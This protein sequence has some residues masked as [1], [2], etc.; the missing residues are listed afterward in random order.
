MTSPRLIVAASLVTFAACTGSVQTS[1]TTGPSQPT[2]Y[3]VAPRPDPRPSGPTWDSTGWTL[4]GTQQVNGSTDRDT[5]RV[6][7]AARWDKL[8]LVVSDSDL[9]L[10][11]F[12]VIFATG[13]R[14]SPKLKH[15]FHEGERTAS[16]DLPGDDRHI[17]SL[18][19]LYKNT[20]GGG[21]AR[22]EVYGKDL[23]N[24]RPPVE[25][26]PPP[27][28]P[29]VEFDPTG[30][31]LLGSQTVDGKKDRDTYVVGDKKLQHIDL[32]MIV[33]KDS[34]VDITDFVI[35]FG[36][37][38][39]WTPPNVKHTFREGQRSHKIDLPNKDRYIKTIDV[40][41]ANLPGG[42]RAR[43]EIY[44]KDTNQG[45]PPKRK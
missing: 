24:A 17:A 7:K 23:R 42:G 32:I 8:T 20:P 35:T 13:E 45:A 5:I 3:P 18:E 30:W 19:L 11:D 2:S 4:L 43:V 39:K 31:S 40:K 36:N 12:T 25:P 15:R 16:I 1:G 33:V 26:P 21:S 9:D 27:P 37:N 34:D 14:W 41:Y 44:G 10:I 22:L 38:S 29:V 28:P 6:A